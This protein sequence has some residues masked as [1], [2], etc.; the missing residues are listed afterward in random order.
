VSDGE[1]FGGPFAGYPVN[2]D[3]TELLFTSK[4][5]RCRSQTALEARRIL[6]QRKSHDAYQKFCILYV[7]A[8]WDKSIPIDSMM[9]SRGS[10]SYLFFE[11]LE[12]KVM[13]SEEPYKVLHATLVPH[14]MTYGDFY[15]LIGNPASNANLNVQKRLRLMAKVRSLPFFE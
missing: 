8:Q 5:V 3:T 1:F 2:I 10:T 4:K 6:L 9:L 12:A 7:I 13:E 15:N 11:K 14:F